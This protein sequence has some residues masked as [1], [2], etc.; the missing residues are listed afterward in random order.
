MFSRINNLRVLSMLMMMGRLNNYSNFIDQGVRLYLPFPNWSKIFCCPGTNFLI[1]YLQNDKMSKS[2]SNIK[3][4]F[5]SV[6]VKRRILVLSLMLSTI[7]ASGKEIFCTEKPIAS[8][9]SPK[10]ESL[11]ENSPYQPYNLIT[12]GA[13]R[14]YQLLI[15]PSKGSACPMHPNCS[16]YGKMAFEKYNPVKAFIVTSD[17]LHRCGHDLKNYNIVEIGGS[18]RFY[19]PLVSNNLFVQARPTTNSTFIPQESG[20]ESENSRIFAFAEALFK[21]KDF[22]SALTEYQRLI[23]YFP[24]S[25]F[26]NLATKMILQCYYQLG[27]YFEAVHWGKRMLKEELDNALETKFYIGKSYFKLNNFPKAR[28]EFEEVVAKDNGELQDKA[29]LL[30][31]LSLVNEE[32]WNEAQ[33]CFAKVSSNSG[34]YKKAEELK[35]LAEKG[36]T[37]KQKSPVV[38][39]VLAIIPGG[40][41]LYNG[42]RQTALA[43][44]IVN[45]LFFWGTAEVFKKDNDSLKPI[46]GILSFGWYTGNIYGSVVSTHRKNERIKKDFLEQFNIGFD[47]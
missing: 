8:T 6:L 46:M 45:S 5:L 37:L 26:E 14:T 35:G 12:L 4:K 36:P 29:I 32:K 18:V 21:S 42:Y 27:Q 9:V 34:F 38:A 24:N 44:F 11:K 7:L 41:Y 47:F 22:A 3:S 31:G 39:G 15:A 13:I 16:L 40:G 17:R 30:S 19:D 25:S 2:E 10:N 43:S 1:K 33:E 28:E 20:S 23:S